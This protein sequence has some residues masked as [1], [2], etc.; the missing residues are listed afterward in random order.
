MRIRDLRRATFAAVVALAGPDFDRAVLRLLACVQDEEEARHLLSL[1]RGNDPEGVLDLFRTV[2]GL[3]LPARLAGSER[4]GDFSDEALRDLA[5]QWLATEPD[6]DVRRRLERS[7]AKQSEKKR[8]SA[9]QAVGPPDADLSSD[10][11]RSWASQAPDAGLEWIE[12]TFPPL[13][14]NAVRVFQGLA[15]GAI[16]EVRGLDSSGAWT[17]LWAGEQ[18]GTTPGP[19]RFDFATTT[20]PISRVRIALDTRRS[21]GW[22]EIDAVEIGGPDGSSWAIAARASSHFGQ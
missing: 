5:R 16:T 8:W 2:S 11:P 12:L 9:D 17:V 10:D 18:S 21:V 4:L 15:G 1:A 20:R 14:A 13:R 19:Y 3:D 22:N 7:M 6:A